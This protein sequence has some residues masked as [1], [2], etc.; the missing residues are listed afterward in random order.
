V[1]DLARTNEQL[2]SLAATAEAALQLAPDA[3]VVFAGNN[4]NL[5]ETPEVSPYAP[6]VADRQAYGEALAADGLAGPL[7]LGRRRLAERAARAFARL[8][9]IASGAGLPLVALVPEVN[10]ADWEDRQPVAW[11]P[12]NGTPSWWRALRRARRRLA[13]GR[14]EDA[15]AAA[16]EMV[17]LDGETCPTSC[18]LL[19]R[20]FLGQGDARRAREA[21][22]AAVDAGAYPTLA[23]LGAPQATHLARQVQIRGGERFGLE[24]VDLRRLFAEATGG[25]LP[26]RRLF[27]DY[28]HLTAEG[29]ELA[30]AAAAAPLLGR[31]G[32]RT[33]GWRDLLRLPAAPRRPP[34]EVEATALLGAA[35]H[36]AHRLL[37]LEDKAPLLERWCRAALAASAAAAR[38]MR[39]LLAARAAPCPAVLTAAQRANLAADCPLLLAHGWRWDHL[40][41]D[42]L[43]V[44]SAVLGE[45]DPG[46]ADRLDE[47]LVASFGAGPEPVDLS[48]AP[49][50]WE[51][52]DRFFPETMTFRDLPGRAT[53][54]APW[55][56]SSFA[57]VAGGSRPVELEATL[58]LPA[59]GGWE[60]RRAG[61]VELAVNGRS[62]GRLEV[63]E[64]WSRR[65]VL[66][67]PA[68]LRRGLNRVTL[69]WP[70]P[71]PAGSE[72][73]AWAVRR[74]ELG[75]EAD[76][77]PVFG[78]VFS[79]LARAGG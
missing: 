21:A 37:A 57:L 18:R 23:C 12:G 27:L 58:R 68:L 72:A 43:G 75:L 63:G 4:W 56:E 29:I 53:Y 16:W 15:A 31:V 35:I 19:A 44:L 3:L 1:I 66:V 54:R 64:R 22:I 40:D 49:F 65:R 45:D 11:L 78:E 69:A 38:S 51:P 77:H 79:L 67:P 41:A 20:A 13:E 47:R 36:S 50:L 9:E 70:E 8:A 34:A 7:D 2:A 76:L 26:G 60:G 14:F 74:L 48:R 10:L 33:L 5:L 62:A 17:D 61:V 73:L 46:A 32:E 59:I 52:L 25:E 24:I 55:P 39:D 6:S 30:M 42:L 71:P 28:C